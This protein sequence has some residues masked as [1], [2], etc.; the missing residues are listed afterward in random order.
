R[1]VGSARVV[2]VDD[3]TA[4]EPTAVR[5]RKPGDLSGGGEEVGAVRAGADVPATVLEERRQSC[6]RRRLGGIWIVAGVED[7]VVVEQRILGGRV[8][9]RR[10]DRVG[11]ETEVPQRPDVLIDRSRENSDAR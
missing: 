11:L 8:D 2:P 7:D 9:G 1:A 4:T 10:R 6:A 5:R 3:A